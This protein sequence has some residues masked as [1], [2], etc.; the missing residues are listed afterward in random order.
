MRHPIQRLYYCARSKFLY[1]GVA[2]TIQVFDTGVLLRQWEAPE[3]SN[4]AGEKQQ[5]QQQKEE[6]QSDPTTEQ[7]GNNGSGIVEV[8]MAMGEEEGMVVKKRRVDDI[9]FSPR[10]TPA[11]PAA[12]PY[13]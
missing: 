6:T 2:D 11:T 13:A 5:Q 8:E 10:V 4:V 9:T 3:I 7:S 12:V 1:A